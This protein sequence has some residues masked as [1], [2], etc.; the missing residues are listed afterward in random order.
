MLSLKKLTWEVLVSASINVSAPGKLMLFGE[1]AVVYGY[2]CIVTAVDQRV[3]VKAGFNGKDELVVNAPQLGVSGYRK[4]VD[5]LCDQE[6]PKQVSFIEAVV[7]RFY[8]NYGLV[9]GLEIATRSDFSHSYGFG[10]S[11]A[12]TMATATALSKLYLIK[13]SKKQLFDLCYQ[14]VLDIQGVGSGFDLAAALWGKTLLYKKGARLV[15]KM[16]LDQL[17]IVV[18][19]SG[20]KADTPTLVRQVAEFKR[21]KPRKV[22]QIFNKIEQLVLQTEKVIIQKDW[23]GVG[24]LMNTNQRLLEDLGVSTLKLEKLNK[25][26]LNAGAYGAK[27]S[28]AGGGDCMIAVCLQS[29]RDAVEQALIKAGGEIMP[30]KLNSKGVTWQKK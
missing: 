21:K 8:Q 20:V 5:R 14:A 29:K 30:V 19:Y 22:K 2:S 11:S 26:A 27:L 10:S 24:K 12:I 25:T 9:R 15:K 1:H 28:G 6:M 17:P 3:Y 18:C 13:L 23:Q 4:K 7:R 16:I